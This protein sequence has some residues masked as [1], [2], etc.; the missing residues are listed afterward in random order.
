MNKALNIALWA[1]GVIVLFMLLGFAESNKSEVVFNEL[2]VNVDNSKGNFFITKKEMEEAVYNMGYQ[3][4]NDLLQDIDLKEMEHYFDNNPSIKKAEVYSSIDGVL[5]IDVV[6]RTP[7]LRVF[8]RNGDSYYIDADGYLM[9]LSKSYTSRV[10]VVN[11]AV[12]APYNVNYLH[13]LGKPLAE[14]ETIKGREQLKALYNAAKI[15]RNNPFWKAQVAQLYINKDNDLELIPKV[16]DH[17]IVVGDP[18]DIETRLNKLM[19]FYKEGL[20]KTGWNEYSTIN[21]KFKNQVVCTKK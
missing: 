5:R 21:L 10:M 13:Q 6:Q 15:I 12:D 8:S 3:L 9:P 2:F 14:G 11:G 19:V 20:S 4:N 18:A 1:L 7:I 16:G 17:T